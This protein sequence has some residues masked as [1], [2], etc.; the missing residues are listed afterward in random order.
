MGGVMG[1]VLARIKEFKEIRDAENRPLRFVDT[2]DIRLNVPPEAVK[3]IYIEENEAIVMIDDLELIKHIL[4]R[5]EAIEA[6]L[7]IAP[8]PKVTQ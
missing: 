4:K 8:A 1:M 7:G 6:R 2:S 5:I 3:V